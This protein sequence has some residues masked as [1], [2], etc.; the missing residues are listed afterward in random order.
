[1]VELIPRTGFGDILL[2]MHEPD[3]L[4]VLG[5][6]DSKEVQN[7]SSPSGDTHSWV[8]EGI[9]VE[10]D[11]DEDIQYRLARITVYSSDAI[12]L[13][14]KPIGLSESALTTAYPHA[15]LDW[16]AGT[17]KDFGDPDTDVS[18]MLE[19]GRVVNVTLYPK[20][21]EAGN[22]PQWPKAR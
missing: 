14:S 17:L 3:V 11:F 7:E 20:Y 22:N 18:L 15:R 12:L 6:P 19:E 8:Y 2:G 16:A 21:D 13:G 1:M 9:G 10:L 5:E 4:R